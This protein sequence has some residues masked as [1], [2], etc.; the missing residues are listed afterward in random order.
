MITFLHSHAF[1]H[2]YTVL[3]IIDGCF[4]FNWCSIKKNYINDTTSTC[5]LTKL[6]DAVMLHYAIFD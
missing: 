4:L 3:F 1:E 6:L 2:K 5:I